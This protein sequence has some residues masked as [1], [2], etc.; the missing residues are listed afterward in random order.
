LGPIL[1]FIY[2]GGF[3]LTPYKNRLKKIS[4]AVGN[5]L[6]KNKAREVFLQRKIM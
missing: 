4:G 5:Y 1:N 2:L 6:E 3:S